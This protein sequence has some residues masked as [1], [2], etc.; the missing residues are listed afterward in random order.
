MIK[1]LVK[2]GRE[3]RVRKRTIIP[4]F[5][6]LICKKTEIKNDRGKSEQKGGRRKRIGREKNFH[7]FFSI[8]DMQ[9]KLNKK[10][11]MVAV[12]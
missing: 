10:I 5:P 4:C 6:F 2:K 7:N 9:E 3:R 8:F 12:R 11:G 1:V